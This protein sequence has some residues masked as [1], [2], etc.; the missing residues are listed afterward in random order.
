MHLHDIS[1]YIIYL[2]VKGCVGMANKFEDFLNAIKIGQLIHRKEPERRRHTV[3]CVLAIVGAVAVIAAIAYA[4]Y[5][6]M[7]PRYLDDFD[8]DFDDYEDA[9]DITAESDEEVATEEQ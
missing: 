8:D 4:V 1:P 2:T 6:Y 5:R 7:N 3:M 9:A